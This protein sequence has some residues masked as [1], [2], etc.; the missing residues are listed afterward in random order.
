MHSNAKRRNIV[1]GERIAAVLMA[2][3]LGR[4]MRA[5]G[6]GGDK[7]LRLLAGKSLLE[8]VMARIAPQAEAMAINANGD[9]AH[10]A[11]FG[12]DVI[13][14]AVPDYPGPLAGILAGMRW[15]AGQ[16]F[17]LVLS[18]PTD[19]P[20]L[21]Y[22]LAARLIE[23]KAAASAQ[24]ACAASGGRIH[25]VVGLWPVRLA[26]GLE[27]DLRGG[28]RKVEDWAAQHGVA[29]AEFG[30]QGGDPFF[31]VNTPEDLAEAEEKLRRAEKAKP[32]SAMPRSGG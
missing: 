11:A 29:R 25:P 28:M 22:D 3:G 4:R 17:A 14:D 16:G 26:D 18:V 10:F 12:L 15:A 8:H 20:F 1:D 31:N 9:P 27:R 6:G 19:T 21:P 24:A 7:P 5:D 23:A 13:A 2:G 30:T 32:S